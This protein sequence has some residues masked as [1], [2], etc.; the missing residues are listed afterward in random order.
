MLTK[1]NGS[2]KPTTK[3]QHGNREVIVWE[4]DIVQGKRTRERKGSK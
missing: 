4:E 2:P 1:F 3:R